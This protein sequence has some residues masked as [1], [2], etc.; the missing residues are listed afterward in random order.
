MQVATALNKYLTE[1]FKLNVWW[2]KTAIRSGLSIATQIETGLT[3]SRNAVIIVT[4][5][6]LDGTFWSRFER[7]PLY[8]MAVVMPVLHGVSF[9]QVSKVSAV[10]ADR[11]GFTTKESTNLEIAAGIYSA[12]I[13]PPADHR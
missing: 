6:Y 7:G 10:L 9:E 2:D 12:V 13:L 4:S 8:R 1:G 11:A 3:K 5:K